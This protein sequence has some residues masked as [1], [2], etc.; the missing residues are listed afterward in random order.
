M[1]KEKLIDQNISDLRQPG[2]LPLKLVTWLITGAAVGATAAYFWDPARGLK[3]RHVLKDQ[4]IARSK[5]LKEFATGVA[6]DVG[7]RLRGIAAEARGFVNFQPVN[8][9]TLNQRI[10]SE[11]GRKIRHARSIDSFVK[12]GV[13][14]LAGPILADEVS[15]LL[16][17]VRRVRGVRDIVNRLQ[18][19]EVADGISGLQGSGPEYLQ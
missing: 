3:R 7:N 5:E 12:D 10:R 15:A 11:F 13:V 17:C 4:T 6:L 9:E 8:D 16:R 19:S 2:E 14:T 18:I 1:S